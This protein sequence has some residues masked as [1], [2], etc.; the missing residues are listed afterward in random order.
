LLEEDAHDPGLSDR[1]TAWGLDRLLVGLLESKDD[2]EDNDDEGGGN[3][4]SPHR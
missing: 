4:L 1:N 2:D 3:V